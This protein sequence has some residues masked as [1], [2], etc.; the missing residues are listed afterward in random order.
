M[1]HN[2]IIVLKWD[3]EESISLEDALTFVFSV[4]TNF[5]A[6]FVVTCRDRSSAAKS[7]F[8]GLNCNVS[9][10][11]P[12][13]W[14]PHSVQIPYLAR[15]WTRRIKR[16]MSFGWISQG[17]TCVLGGLHIHAYGLS[18]NG[19]HM[20]DY[21]LGRWRCLGMQMELFISFYYTHAFAK[22]WCRAKS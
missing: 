10:I 21:L 16:A 14:L 18:H 7:H 2:R 17:R 20:R 12:W 11:Y 13:Y 9:R 8:N 3:S 15:T 6:V 5:F 1:A 4:L 19:V 22:V